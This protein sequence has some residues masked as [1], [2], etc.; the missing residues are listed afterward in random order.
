M[1]DSS[2]CLDATVVAQH[3][4]VKPENVLIGSDGYI[5]IADLG[6]AKIVDDV[7]QSQWHSVVGTAEYFPPEV[8]R[9]TEE[10]A[11][12]QGAE[13]GKGIDLWGLGVTIYN[14]LTGKRPFLPEGM[15]SLDSVST[16]TSRHCIVLRV[17]ST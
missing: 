17:R 12:M 16:Q 15:D 2:F 4:D 1:L 3:R 7:E 8:A 10:D 5:K 9:V 13:Y 6:F 14:C 11:N